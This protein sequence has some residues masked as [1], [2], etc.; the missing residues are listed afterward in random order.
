MKLVYKTL[1]LLWSVFIYTGATGTLIFT[2]LTG[3]N[4]AGIN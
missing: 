2:I 4:N 1:E 3:L